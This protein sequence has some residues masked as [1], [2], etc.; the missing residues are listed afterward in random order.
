M[1]SQLPTSTYKSDARANARLKV[2]ED[3]DHRTPIAPRHPR[4][5]KSCTAGCRHGSGI[6]SKTVV[7]LTVHRGFESLPLR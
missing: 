4:R 6:V 3:P 7:G 5:M 2:A 1:T